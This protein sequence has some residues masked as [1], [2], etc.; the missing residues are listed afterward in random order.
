[1]LEQLRNW[2]NGPREYTSGVLLYL[3]LG[4]NEALKHL[5]K[6]SKNDY[7]VKRLQQEL[8][9]ICVHLKSIKYGNSKNDETNSTSSTK[10]KKSFDEDK[11]NRHRQDSSSTKDVIVPAPA[12]AD[13]I[14]SQNI[15]LYEACH[16]EANKKYKEAMNTRAV[17]F[18]MLPTDEYADANQQDFVLQRSDLAIKVV[19][20]YNEASD[21]F[22]RAAYVKEHGRLP[23]A[24]PVTD[25]I[26]MELVPEYQVKQHLDNR[27]KNYNKM[28]KK[29]QT[30]ETVLKIQQHEIDIKILER[31]WHSLT[32]AK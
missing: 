12:S 24:A 13:E 27:R 5:L 16:Q 10:D 14:S 4:D 1:M 32:Q 20:L 11:R 6:K 26:D 23:D 9:A 18:A 2:L 25:V 17:L 29:V 15:R 7:N 21:L 28:L 31:R 3:H 30:P 22:D 8:L 19:N